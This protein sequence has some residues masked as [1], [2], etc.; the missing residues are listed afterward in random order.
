MELAPCR[1]QDALTT[2]ADRPAPPLIA[3][4]HD[5][6]RLPACLDSLAMIGHRR[7]F[8][9]VVAWFKGV[10][11]QVSLDWARRFGSRSACAGCIPEPSAAALTETCAPDH[12]LFGEVL[13]WA[14][15]RRP[16]ISEEVWDVVGQLLAQGADGGALLDSDRNLRAKLSRAGLPSPR[17]IASFGHALSTIVRLQRDGESIE[18]ASHGSG[19]SD[20]ASFSRACMNLWGIRP[21]EARSVLGWR[22]LAWRVFR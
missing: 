14:M 13:S 8:L 9:T 19:Y 17:R 1:L 15:R 10:P 16:G 22:W 12:E 6:Y 7:P 3:V 4:V 5:V 20:Q 11:P 18:A 2:D 21:G